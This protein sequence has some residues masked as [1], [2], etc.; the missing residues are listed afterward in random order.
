MSGKLPNILKLCDIPKV[1]YSSSNAIIEEYTKMPDRFTSL[2]D[3]PKRCN[4]LCY[5]CTNTISHVPLFVPSMVDAE[6]IERLD[7]TLIC[8]PSCLAKQISTMPDRDRYMRYARELVWRISKI[9][10]HRQSYELTDD[11]RTL[12]EYGGETDRREYR[13]SIYLK[14][15]DYFDAIQLN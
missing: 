12:R 15:K 11:K 7:K 4:Y 10:T 8:S 5:T 14:N 2:K 3:W 1:N 13:E 9:P 6:S